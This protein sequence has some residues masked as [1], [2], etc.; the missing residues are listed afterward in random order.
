MKDRYLRN[1]NTINLAEQKRLYD[2]KVCIIGLG[3]LG[4]G[5]AEML[6]R[7]GVGSLV[8]VDGDFFKESNLNR[9]ILCTEELIGVSKADAAENRIKQINSSI[10][11]R[12]INSF[13]NGENGDHILAESDLVVDCLDSV[14][15]RFILQDAAKN[16]K[17]P[18]VSGAIAGTAG[19]VCTIFPDDPGFEKIYG[20]KGRKK[21]E[22]AE[23]NGH[24]F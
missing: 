4:G 1:F 17:I 5:V 13:L 15:A 21:A 10:N 16:A 19:Q 20:K 9:Q 23:K 22:G 14:E 18:I 8:L 3:G 24:A 11:I 2:S 12:K 7:T 6:A